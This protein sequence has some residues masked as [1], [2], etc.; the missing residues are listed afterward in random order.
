MQNRIQCHV[1]NDS[2]PF[3]QSV[4]PKTTHPFH[5]KRIPLIW[6]LVGCLEKRAGA[7][8]FVYQAQAYAQ[9]R[10]SESLIIEHSIVLLFAKNSGPPRKE[11]CHSNVSGPPLSHIPPEK[12]DAED[13]FPL[14]SL[15]RKES[16]LKLAF[17][18]SIARFRDQSDTDGF[19]LAN[20][21]FL[22][23]KKT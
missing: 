2:K 5:S 8:Q 11:S 14:K 18:T 3:Q 15:R 17:A 10:G 4:K 9:A 22:G 1:Q 19:K 21:V 13:N 16:N 12:Y 6:F 7:I 20:R 23:I